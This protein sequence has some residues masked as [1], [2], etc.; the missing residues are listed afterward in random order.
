M[1]RTSCLTA[2]VLAAAAIAGTAVPR[3]ASAHWTPAP[4]DFVTAG[5]FVNKD[6]G[7]LANFGAHGGCKN[8][9]FW[10]SV[11]FVDHETNFHLSSI[12]ITG[13]LIDPAY[14]NTRDICGWART[15]D[16]ITVRF[17][18][19]LTDNGEPGVNDRFGIVVDTLN[20]I[21][22]DRFYLVRDRKLADGGPGGGNVQLHGANP[23]TTASPAMQ[24]L[25]EWQ[26]CGD[27]NSPQ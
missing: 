4:C 24:S 1:L 17:R 7:K 2:A 18:V 14:P 12:E 22:G 10:G 13:Y 16:E 21:P 5:G 27:L 6:D 19:R 3:E 15:N 25:K 8:D 9:K 11:N 23:S 20:Q 26:M